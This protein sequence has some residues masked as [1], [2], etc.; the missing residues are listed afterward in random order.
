MDHHAMNNQPNR[1]TSQTVFR[2]RCACGAV[3]ARPPAS[4]MA[5]D[6][7]SRIEALELLV[8]QQ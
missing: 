1:E 3:V 8:L 5:S 2:G 4:R 7:A 6:K